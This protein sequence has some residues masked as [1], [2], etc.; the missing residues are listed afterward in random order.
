[1]A[2]R[3][4]SLIDLTDLDDAHRADG[5][6]ALVQRALEHRT[7]AV[8][9]WPEF[10]E[11]VV[12]GRGTEDLAVATVVD[13]PSG[14]SAVDTVVAETA[15][16][17]HDGAD[18]IDLVLPYRSLLAGDEEIARRM[19]ETIA[20]VAHRSERHLKV[21]LETGELSDADMIRRA[22]RIAVGAG[23]D[24][25]KTSTG[26]T[27]T[28]ATIESVDAMIDVVV[29]TG[30]R[31]G[32][33]PSGGIRTLDDAAGYLELVDRRLGSDWATPATFRFGASGLLDA[34]LAEL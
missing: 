18:E 19:V 28:G 20:G 5:I 30:G 25:L 24:F 34:A 15:T 3:I 4:I 21:I 27:S 12:N 14:T 13:F 17:I 31:V 7:A 8:C 33:K 26:K 32:L 22:S 9:V 29:E 16:A 1:M 6:G 10:V 11:R 23:A 2:R